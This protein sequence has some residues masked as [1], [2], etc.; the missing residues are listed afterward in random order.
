M[1][2]PGMMVTV[3][4]SVKKVRRV[5][6]ELDS[7]LNPQTIAQ[8]IRLIIGSTSQAT[9]TLSPL[10][11]GLASIA[12]IDQEGFPPQC[13]MTSALKKFALSL[14]LS[15]F[16][17]HMSHTLVPNIYV[18]YNSKRERERERANFFNA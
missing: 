16:E 12:E 15:L 6:K 11:K 9:V 5:V 3:G 13:C 4:M 18:L 1:G 17:A 2:E 10:T 8:K 7:T 14:S